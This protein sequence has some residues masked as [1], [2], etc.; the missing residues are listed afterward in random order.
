M[1]T[2]KTCPHGAEHHVHLSGTKVRAMLASDELPPAE[3]TRPE[4]AEILMEAYR[5]TVAS[6]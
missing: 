6:C 4:V 3:F 2:A 5:E 1:A